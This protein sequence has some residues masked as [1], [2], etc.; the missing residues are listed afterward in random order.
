MAILYP[1]YRNH[2]QDEFYITNTCAK[3]DINNNV[4]DV[5]KIQEWLR[6]W[7]Q[8]YPNFQTTIRVDGDFGNATESAI[9]NFQRK[10]GLPETGYISQSDFDEL[11]LPLYNAFEELLITES[12]SLRSCILAAANQHLNNYARETER[13]I[14]RN[15]IISNCGPW[16][17]SYME[18]GD[19][20][21]YFWC[22]GFVCTI[23][24]FAC[25]H[26]GI[27]F[28]S[29]IANT[30]SCDILA[31]T[32]IA[33]G[34]FISKSEARNNWNLIQPGDIFLMKRTTNDW[35]HTG[36][37]TH[38]TDSTITTI[39]G[40]TNMANSRNGFGVLS[41]VRNFRVNPIEFITVN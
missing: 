28:T 27:D 20:D 37:V 21:T 19:G 6:I 26:L 9:R 2:F 31:Q 22:A 36:I 25:T 34:R 38:V 8:N 14:R 33:D 32:A 15:K 30:E 16:V 13:E 12:M 4:R 18:G 29:I 7:G 11:C 41:R 3:G 39:E 23:L 5:F 24:D 10:R 1:W 35:N 17:R 40:N